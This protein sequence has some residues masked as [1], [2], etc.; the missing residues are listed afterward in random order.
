MRIL[1]SKILA[2]EANS[3][4][5]FTKRT[6]KVASELTKEEAESFTSLC[7]F[8]TSLGPL[9]YDFNA[10]VYK[11]KGLSFYTLTLLKDA[12]LINFDAVAGY[13]RVGLK[14][15]FAV[16]YFGN[17]VF[18]SMLPETLPAGQVMLTTSGQQLSKV[19]QTTKVEEFSTYLLRIWK[20]FQPLEVLNPGPDDAIV[21]QQMSL[22]EAGNPVL[23]PLSEATKAMIFKRLK[24]L[25]AL[26][27]EK[28]TIDPTR[29]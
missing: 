24:D 9:I 26:A 3:P 8:N 23:A 29:A 22:N 4:G 12:G 19:C 18:F 27:S 6:L 2:G 15:P 14:E 1:W 5:S 16:T 11:A 21:D 25:A 17:A 20:D 28:G 7:C 10:P 13:S